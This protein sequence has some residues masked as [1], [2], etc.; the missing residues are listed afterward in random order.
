MLGV[1]ALAEVAAAVAESMHQRTEEIRC[2]TVGLQ[3]SVSALTQQRVIPHAD[4]PT[5]S[6]MSL[7]TQPERQQ[8]SAMAVEL[9]TR[10]HGISAQAR[11]LAYVACQSLQAAESG[12]FGLQRL[13][14]SI[15]PANDRKHGVERRVERRKSSDTPAPT[16]A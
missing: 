7:E 4:L 11:Q 10:I 12:I 15:H 13:N 6:G 3:N 14:V 5:P 2:L 16:H 1:P 8:R 9:A